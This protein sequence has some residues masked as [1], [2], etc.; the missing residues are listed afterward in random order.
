M[1]VSFARVK[2]ASLKK[3]LEE[4]DPLLMRPLDFQFRRLVWLPCQLPDFW[5][6]LCLE[7][8]F[9]FR[10]V[11]TTFASEEMVVLYWLAQE[12]WLDCVS[13]KLRLWV[14]V[15]FGVSAAKAV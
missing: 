13:G 6:L 3:C 12:T 14:L 9:S 1:P 5:K 10:A 11:V 2:I 4:M 7:S 8:P 15:R